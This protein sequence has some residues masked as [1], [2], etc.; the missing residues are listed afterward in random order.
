MAVVAEEDSEAVV[1]V[2]VEAG[3]EAL[4]AEVVEVSAVGCALLLN[5]FS[6]ANSLIAIF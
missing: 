4:A 3:V 6:A 5:L 2:V 1:G